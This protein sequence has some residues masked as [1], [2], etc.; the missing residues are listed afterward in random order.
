METMYKTLE[1]NVKECE[2][3]DNPGSLTKV[4]IHG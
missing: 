4:Q 3:N 2:E 1:N